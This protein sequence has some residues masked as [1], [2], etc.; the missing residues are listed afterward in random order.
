[1]AM[2]RIHADG[3]HVFVRTI[4]QALLTLALLCMSFTVFETLDAFVNGGRA[5]AVQRQRFAPCGGNET[6]VDVHSCSQ[7][8]RGRDL[9]RLQML[10][11]RTLG[12]RNALGH[13]I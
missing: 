1:M 11:T 10:L 12:T 8:W 13:G 9:N 5:L 4:C 7:L 2:E 6:W 3:A